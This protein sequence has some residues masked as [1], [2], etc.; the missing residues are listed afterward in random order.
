MTPSFSLDRMTLTQVQG[1][2]K[3][4]PL[5]GDP[6]Y[7]PHLQ[8]LRRHQHRNE[9]KTGTKDENVLKLN[10]A[11]LSHM[12]VSTSGRA[13]SVYDILMSIEINRTRHPITESIHCPLLS[14]G[15]DLLPFDNRRPRIKVHY[16]SCTGGVSCYV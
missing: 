12:N 13:C 5:L 14:N 1:A 10:F 9:R 8:C 3:P 7:F 2:T 16:C 11:I 15:V 4:S 6:P